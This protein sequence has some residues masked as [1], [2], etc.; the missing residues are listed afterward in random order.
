MTGFIIQGKFVIY[1]RHFV[2]S[3][4]RLFSF[5]D[6]ETGSGP[7]TNWLLTA[8]SEA[9]ADLKS[10]GQDLPLSLDGWTLCLYEYASR[11]FP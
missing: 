2:L 10:L 6:A 8:A 7:G 1:Y 9:V 4:T 11:Y 5:Q 3:T